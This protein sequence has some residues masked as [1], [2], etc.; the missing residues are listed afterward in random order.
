MYSLL[1]F[2]CNILL[3]VDNVFV[4]SPESI[5]FEKTSH[6][7]SP[8]SVAQ[9]NIGQELVV[10][11]QFAIDLSDDGRVGGLEMKG[12]NGSIILRNDEWEWSI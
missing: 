5:L 11:N 10:S 7:Q 3:V 6:W 9:F 2:H 8:D 4:I 1:A 12:G